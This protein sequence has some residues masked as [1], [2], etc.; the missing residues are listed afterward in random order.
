MVGEAAQQAQEPQQQLPVQ[1]SDTPPPELPLVR[2]WHPRSESPS[3]LNLLKFVL[4]RLSKV[5]TGGALFH[6]WNEILAFTDWYPTWKVK[7]YDLQRLKN[8]VKY[9][10]MKLLNI[11][12]FLFGGGGEELFCVLEGVE[13][14]VGVGELSKKL[15]VLAGV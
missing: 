1:L 7:K 8:I 14:Q 5:R 3:E 4:L 11:V 2:D 12:D 9:R 15:C 13:V 10:D 6:C